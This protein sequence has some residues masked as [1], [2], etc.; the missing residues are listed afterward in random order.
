MS[1][2]P[3]GR[4]AADGATAGT[5]ASDEPVSP[6]RARD[7]I[8]ETAGAVDIVHAATRTGG[9]PPD[10]TPPAL[11]G[12]GDDGADEDITVDD[13][14][15]LRVHHPSDLLGVVLS[16]VGAVL[17]MGVATFA[18]NTTTGVAEDVHGFAAVLQRIL[19]VPVQLLAALVFLTDII[20][21]FG[22]LA[23]RR[24]GRQVLEALAATAAAAV[25]NEVVLWVVNEFAG[26]ELQRG[27]SIHRGGD[28]VTTL[29]LYVAILSALLTVVGPRGRRRVVAWGWN[30]LWIAVGVDLI[31]ARV[32]LPGLV[33]ALLIG[34]VVGLATRYV[35]GVQSERAYGRAL[36]AGVRRAGFDPARLTRVADQATDEAAE[37]R[38]TPAPAL[39][40]APAARALTRSTAHRVYELETTDGQHLDVVVID[41]DRQVVGTLSRAWRSLRMRG[42]EGRSVVS[43][44]QATERAALLAYAARAAGVRTPKLLS[45]AEAEDSMLLVQERP[46]NAVPLVDI[47]P[48]RLTDRV[49]GEIWRQL[50]LAH[51]AGIAHRALTSDVVLAERTE[52]GPLVWLTGWEQGD[53]ASSE[54]ARRMDVTQLVALLALRVGAQRALESAATVLAPDDIAA[55]GPLLQTVALPRETRDEMRAHKA[56]LADLRAALVARLP[57]AEVQPQQLVRFG[58]RTVV[59]I[60][61]TTIAV[62]VVLATINVDQIG[63]ALTTGDWRWIALAFALGLVTL[64]GAGLAVVALSPVKVSVWHATLMQ[65]AATYLALAVPAGIGPAALHLRLLQ[66]RGVSSTLAAATAALVQVLQ[67]VVTVLLLL[68][69]SLASGRPDSLP[70]SPLVLLI[71]GIVVACLAATM[72]FPRVRTWVVARVQPILEQTWPRLLE[73]LGQPRRLLLAVSGNLVNTL[74]YVTAFW[75]CMAALGQGNEAD[76]VQVAIIYLTGNTVGSIVPTPGGVGAVEAALGTA[77]ATVTGMNA[78][79]AFSIAVL[80]RVL[81]YWLRIP[82][83]WTAMRFLQRRG[84]L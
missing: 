74:G 78:G 24:L 23:V 43:L 5:P 34:R 73:V 8:A 66:R 56:V 70:I 30:L 1:A 64:V 84:E 33:V 20:L 29:P 37:R 26:S 63:H 80:F 39:G 17:V 49:L 15:A 9:T 61:M 27:L 46:G 79:V 7:L 57:Q 53:V 75:C 4:A 22:N 69:L 62:F 10:E 21:V 14:P 65:T 52:D 3:A 59:T 50:Q 68:V 12:R 6:H 48:D 47:P 40:D 25:L 32:S 81:T 51:D 82:L 18:P 16:V 54:L 36:V 77:L 72:L 28:W 83:G 38:G 55:I 41:G 58:A 67:F 11:L 45:V 44:R 13:V 76:L 42:I 60:L 19:F 71:L 35:S 31:T 2:T